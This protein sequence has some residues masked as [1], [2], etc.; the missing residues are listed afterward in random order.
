MT[1]TILCAN[2]GPTPGPTNT[3]NIKGHISSFVSVSGYSF[4]DD[5]TNLECRGKGLFL[6]VIRQF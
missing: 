2:P 5:L 1:G 3:T 4:S 6:N